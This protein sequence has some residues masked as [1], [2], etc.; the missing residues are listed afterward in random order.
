MD[1][2][3]INDKAI[4]MKNVRPHTEDAH[5]AMA[6]ACYKALWSTI[7]R[8]IQYLSISTLDTSFGNT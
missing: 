8:H 6:T 1:K 2:K 3:F 5:L 4:N 7:H